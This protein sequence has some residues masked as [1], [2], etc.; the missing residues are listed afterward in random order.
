MPADYAPLLGTMTDEAVALRFGISKQAIAAARK[1][2]GIPAFLPGY[3][4]TR[5]DGT[6]IRGKAVP[7]NVRLSEE[8]HARIRAEAARRGCTATD[9]V[10]GFILALPPA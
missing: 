1:R 6:V 3:T 5:S 4:A 8:E 9:V 2:A 10:R 7:F